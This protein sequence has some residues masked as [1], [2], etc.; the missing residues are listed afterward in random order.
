MGVYLK[1]S[2]PPTNAK[3]GWFAAAKLEVWICDRRQ[4]GRTGINA[5]SLQVEVRFANDG[6]RKTAEKLN[7]SRF[8]A[9]IRGLPDGVRRTEGSAGRLWREHLRLETFDQRDVHRVSERL[10]A[11]AE[12]E[13]PVLLSALL[14]SPP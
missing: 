1:P 6:N 2:Q 8:D 10:R 5:D 12:V 14:A 13:L 3:D 9:A 7:G 11:I 4:S